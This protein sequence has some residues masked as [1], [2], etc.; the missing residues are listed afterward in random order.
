MRFAERLLREA[1]IRDKDTAFANHYLARTALIQ[2]RYSEAI[3]AWTS[4]LEAFE[5]L[6]EA[7]YGLGQSH[8]MNGDKRA[9]RLFITQAVNADMHLMRERLSDLEHIKGDATN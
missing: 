6:P 4:A 7:H 9:A 1:L 2:H 8:M 3:A 5:K